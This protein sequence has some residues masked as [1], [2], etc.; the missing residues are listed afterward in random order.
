MTK[1]INENKFESSTR[2]KLEIFRL[3]VTEWI[4]VF[5]SKP[6]NFKEI[7]IYDL[8]AGSGTD[9]EGNPGSPLVILDAVSNYCSKLIETGQLLKIYFND[10]DTQKIR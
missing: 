6:D 2:V 7:F 9:S 10:N 5:L 1:N 3:Y 8:F 4:P